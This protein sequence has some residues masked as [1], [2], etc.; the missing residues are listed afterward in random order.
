MALIPA[1][2]LHVF[3]LSLPPQLRISIAGLCG[4]ISQCFGHPVSSPIGISPF[5]TRSNF[6]AFQP[7]V[8]CGQSLTVGTQW[9]QGVHSLCKMHKICLLHSHSCLCFSWGLTEIIKHEEIPVFCLLF[10]TFQTKQKTKPKTKKTQKKTKQSHVAS[11]Q[12]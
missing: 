4:K 1:P 8:W 5:R 7:V 11:F 12:F 6:H 3:H 9:G 2:V 10:G